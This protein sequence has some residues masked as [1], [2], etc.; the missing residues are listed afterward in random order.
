MLRSMVILICYNLFVASSFVLS[1]E[2][3]QNEIIKRELENY[4]DD[5]FLLKNSSATDLN[6]LLDVWNPKL[7]YHLWTSTKRENLNNISSL[8]ERDISCYLNGFIK[9]YFWALKSK[10]NNR[11]N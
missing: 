9:G 8:C 4:R 5:L 10:L 3:N 2:L 11:I 6:L 1:I 7:M